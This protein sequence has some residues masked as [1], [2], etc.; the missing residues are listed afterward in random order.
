M[1][2]ARLASSTACSTSGRA[3][4]P[5]GVHAPAQLGRTQLGFPW[6]KRQGLARRVAFGEWRAHVSEKQQSATGAPPT[7]EELLS[8]AEIDTTEKSSP[9]SES[10]REFVDAQLEVVGHAFGAHRRPAQH[11]MRLCRLSSYVSCFSLSRISHVF[12][13][14]PAGYAALNVV[15]Y[16]RT[17]ESFV[18]GEAAD[19]L[20]LTRV[21]SWPITKPRAPPWAKEDNAQPVEQSPRA[22]AAREPSYKNELMLF[23][24]TRGPARTSAGAGTIAYSESLLLSQ[25]AV[26]LS[27]GALASSACDLDSLPP[28]RDLPI[29][30]PLPNP[31]LTSSLSH[32]PLRVPLRPSSLCYP[33]EASSSPCPARGS[34]SASLSPN[35][36]P[37][38]AAPLGPPRAPL[39]PLQGCPRGPTRPGRSLPRRSQARRS[40]RSRRSP[41]VCRSCGRWTNATSCSSEQT[42]RRAPSS[43]PTSARRAALPCRG[44][45]PS[46]PPRSR[47][48][49]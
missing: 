6:S 26:Q 13:P 5:R 42:G 20:R 11:L 23:S 2:G 39:G 43:T 28:D 16:L 25:R 38:P 9:H 12:L 18:S 35:A 7:D 19:R 34:F 24:P 41:R 36:T 33:Q 1:S 3:G 4:Q 46:A 27:T 44:Q 17:T 10:Y 29:F 47:R 8:W 45:P 31:P 49:A 22:E 40:A 48:R 30:P 37:S 21:S 14:L 32:H 15:V